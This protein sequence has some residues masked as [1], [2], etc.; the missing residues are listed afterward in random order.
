M[1]SA[2]ATALVGSSGLANAQA[3]LTPITIATS[4]PVVGSAP[5]FLLRTLKFGEKHGLDVNLHEMGGNS[6]LM[7]D[8]VVTGNATFA[9]P[10]T[11]TVLQAIRQAPISSILRAYCN[12]QISAVISKTAMAK[13]GLTAKSPVADKI[14]AM[15]GMTIGTNPVGA[16]YTQMFEAYL[17]R[18]GLDPTKDVR[19]AY[20]SDTMALVSGIDQG[21]YDAIVSATSVVEQAVTL[22]SATP[23]I[24]GASGEIPGSEAEVVAI[25]IA[26]RDT[27]EKNPDLVKRYLAGMQDSLDALNNN[28]DAT[29]KV[30]REVYFNKLDPVVWDLVWGGLQNGF[31][32]KLI[33]SKETFDYWTT[34]DPKGKDSYKDVDYKKI[35]YGP[36]QS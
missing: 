5:Q 4:I 3:K 26:R 9:T 13:T 14:K 36:A 11:I 19:M 22:G 8:A 28:R 23:W 21:R 2:A 1:Q 20:I 32:K 33:F 34:N 16:T 30:L 7:V 29:G 10:G 17:R 25:T 15:K 35:V 12:N 6:S 18:Y 31:P 24:N 27:V